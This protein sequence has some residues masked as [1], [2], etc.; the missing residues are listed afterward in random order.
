MI[1]MECLRGRTLEFDVDSSNARLNS[2]D[3]SVL[4]GVVLPFR[5]TRFKC[6]MVEVKLPTL[7]GIYVLLATGSNGAISLNQQRVEALVRMGHVVAIDQHDKVINGLGTGRNRK[8]FLLRRLSFADTTFIN[9]P[10]SIDDTEQIGT[11]LLHYFDTTLDFSRNQ[12]SVSLPPDQSTPIQ[13]TPRA[14]GMFSEAVGFDRIRILE[15]EER[16]A[17]ADAG[18]K[19]HDIIHLIDGK[20]VSEYGYWDRVDV[21][22]RAGTTLKLSI[23]RDGESRE[24]ALKLRYDFPYPP[25]WAAEPPEFNPN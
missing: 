8:R 13:V 25:E 24:V 9:L 15:I 18:L 20:P 21:F 12:L 22:S 1:G 16:S 14:S 6:P 17:A 3:K 11:G 2:S 23:K 4:K 7:G 10:V 5:W 19:V